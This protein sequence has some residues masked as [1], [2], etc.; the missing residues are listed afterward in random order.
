MTKV[1]IKMVADL[2][3]T[4]T[5]NCLENATIGQRKS[6]TDEGSLTHL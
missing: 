5:M 1:R 6:W 2:D 3:D 4:A